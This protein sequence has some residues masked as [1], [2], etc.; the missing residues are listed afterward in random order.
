MNLKNEEMS[1]SFALSG[2]SSFMNVQLDE[3]WREQ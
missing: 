1:Q 2:F 3:R